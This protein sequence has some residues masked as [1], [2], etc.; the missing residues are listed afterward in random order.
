MRTLPLF[1]YIPLYLSV[2]MPLSVACFTFYLLFYEGFYILNA[3]LTW[4]NAWNFSWDIRHNYI[5]WKV[6]FATVLYIRRFIL[7]WGQPWDKTGH[8]NELH[9]NMTSMNT[10]SYMPTVRGKSST[11]TSGDARFMNLRLIGKNSRD[12]MIHTYLHDWLLKKNNIK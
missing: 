7:L 10:G 8:L 11:G 3:A 1:Q 4:T 5:F 6:T 9:R 2:L 12:T